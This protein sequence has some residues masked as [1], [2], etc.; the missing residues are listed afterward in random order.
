MKTLKVFVIFLVL[1]FLVFNLSWSRSREIRKIGRSH[2]FSE[3]TNWKGPL[4]KETSNLSLTPYSGPNGYGYTYLDTDDPEGPIYSW[5]EIS[6]IGTAIQ[7]HQWYSRP[8]GYPKDDGTAGP[9]SI[10]FDFIYNGQTFNQ[11]YIG[12]N[13]AVSFTE[14]TLTYDGWFS[15]TWIPGMKFSNALAPFWNDLNLDDSYYGGGT[16]YWWS[17][18]T[19]SFVVEYKD[20]KPYADA[21]TPDS[22]TFEL[23]LTSRDSSITFQYFSVKTPNTIAYEEPAH[24]DSLALIG[25]QD[26]SKYCGLRYYGMGLDGYENLPDSGLAIKFKK[27]TQ[28]THNVAPR[29][30]LAYDY[31]HGDYDQVSYLFYYVEETGTSFSNNS[32][33]VLNLGENQES[34]ISVVCDVSRKDS[35]GNSIDIYSVSAFISDI[36]SQDSVEVS[37]PNSWVQMDRGSYIIKYYTDLSTDQVLLDD[38]IK[39]SS[40]QKKHI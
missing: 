30:I 33:K 7:S 12:T 31:P 8:G 4:S 17:N 34:N 27:T 21:P 14:D 3:K 5:I 38:T 22:V 24:L 26:Q 6:S 28:I 9:F 11:V 18:S 35:L 23:I 13:G 36:S 15:N 2:L 20:V 25:I 39:D 32:V 40:T 29:K 19:D 10:G 37:F 1:S 16:V